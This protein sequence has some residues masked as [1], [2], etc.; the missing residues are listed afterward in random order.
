MLRIDHIFGEG[1]LAE[2]VRVVPVEGSDHAAVVADLEMDDQS[3][4]P[5]SRSSAS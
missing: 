5:R 4:V 1:M 3:P 2:D